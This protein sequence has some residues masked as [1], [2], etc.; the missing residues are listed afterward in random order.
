MTIDYREDFLMT[1]DILS[2]EQALEFL[3]VSEK[4]LKC[5]F[6][7]KTHSMPAKWR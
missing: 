1:D 7:K 4:T 2:L 5:Y 6:G 3:G